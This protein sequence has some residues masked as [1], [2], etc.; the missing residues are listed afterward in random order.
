[1]RSSNDD[2]KH[3]LHSTRARAPTTCKTDTGHFF[4]FETKLIGRIIMMLNL[5][6]FIPD[7]PGGGFKQFWLYVRL[8]PIRRT[9][10]TAGSCGGIRLVS[11]VSLHPL[12]SGAFPLGRHH[13]EIQEG[14]S[15][16]VAMDRAPRGDE[17]PLSRMI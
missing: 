11:F 17:P 16:I 2:A 5:S 10:G 9:G 3:I 14:R 12:D 8:V 13:R 4:R 6:Q 1:M 7:P 15:E